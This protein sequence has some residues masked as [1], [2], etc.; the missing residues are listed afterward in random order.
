MWLI[1]HRAVHGHFSLCHIFFLLFQN[2]EAGIYNVLMKQLE[3]AS[4][5]GLMLMKQL[6]GASECGLMPTEHFS[7]LS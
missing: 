6:E 1:L 3:G 7:A 5:C 2:L 4:E